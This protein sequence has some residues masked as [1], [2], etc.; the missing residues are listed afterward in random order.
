M[1]LPR[2]GRELL[3]SGH[4]ESSG[5]AL[6]DPAVFDLPETVVQFG[7]GAFL[8]GFVDFFIDEAIQR[9]SMA[10]RVVAIGST[11]SG[12]DRALQQQDGLY[13]IVVEGANAEGNVRE[14][15]VVGSLSRALNASSEWYQ[16]LALAAQPALKL[17]FSNTTEVGIA[18]HDGDVIDASPP[19]SFPGKLARFLLE[20]GRAF[21]FPTA[22]GLVVIP[23]E[24]IERNGEKLRELVLALARRWQAEPAFSEWIERAVPFCN[25]LVDRIVPGRPDAERRTALESDFGYRDE[26]MI[27]AEP[28]RLFAIEG[29]TATRSRLQFA[30]AD[31][32]IVLTDDVTPFR[33]RKVRILNGA[34]TLMASIGLLLGCKTVLDAMRHP[35]I[36]SYLK[37]LLFE[38][39]VPSLD[40]PGGEPFA[41][42]VLL[43]FGNPYLR[44]ALRDITVQHTAK[45]RVR[46][47]PSLCCFAERTGR[48]PSALVFGLSAYLQLVRSSLGNDGLVGTDA[49]GERVREVWRSARDDSDATLRRVAETVC[50]DVD[51]WQADL[52]IVPAVVDR[53]TE[54]LLVMTHNEFASAFTAHLTGCPV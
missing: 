29:N 14:C 6:P 54:H 31:E 48:A 15:R 7:T 53:V 16:V 27:A 5:V 23:C 2:L 12:R 30:A 1:T 19:T 22:A 3:A 24:L 33:E 9:G 44:H 8:R 40:V 28:Y 50:L 42:E 4:V 32:G 46:V 39:I 43:R 35:L 47:V 49:D 20:R 51:L 13:T 26:L 52:R 36:A 11:G 18:S 25:T 21:D 10:G 45:M 37:Q 34:H 17:V 41:R 38:E